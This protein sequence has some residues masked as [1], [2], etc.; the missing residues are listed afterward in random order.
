MGKWERLTAVLFC[1]LVGSHSDALAAQR[2]RSTG[3]RRKKEKREIIS[4]RNHTGTHG[5]RRYKQQTAARNY[6]ALLL[7]LLSIES[8]I[9]VFLR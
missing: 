4:N 8:P 5:D 6:Y 7:L 9:D 3:K 1:W 2:T